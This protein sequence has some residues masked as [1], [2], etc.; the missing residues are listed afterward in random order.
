MFVFW[1]CVSRNGFGEKAMPHQVCPPGIK[2]W[3]VLTIR[4]DCGVQYIKLW[5]IDGLIIIIWL[6]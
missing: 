3:I 6:E 5:G 4:H 1:K 2:L